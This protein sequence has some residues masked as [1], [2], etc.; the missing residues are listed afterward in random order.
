MKPLPLKL[1]NKFHNLTVDDMNDSDTVDTGCTTT[2]I[3]GVSLTEHGAKAKPKVCLIPQINFFV[4]VMIVKKFIKKLRECVISK[5]YFVQTLQP[6][7]ELMVKVGLKSVDMHQ[8]VD[9]DMLLDSS[10]T[11]VFMD[12]K[13]AKHNGIAMQKLDKPI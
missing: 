1:Q 7:A 4:T 9:V 12:R 5:K 11:G 8:M 6:K 2:I 10:A 13:F 3:S